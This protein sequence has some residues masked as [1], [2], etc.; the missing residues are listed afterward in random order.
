MNS[1]ECLEN[2]K[3]VA[4]HV[5]AD[6]EFFETCKCW[7]RSVLTLSPVTQILVRLEQNMWNRQY[8]SNQAGAGYCNG[9]RPRLLHPIATTAPMTSKILY[10]LLIVMHS[11]SRPFRETNCEISELSTLSNQQLLSDF[12]WTGY[13]IRTPSLRLEEPRTTSLFTFCPVNQNELRF[14][15]AAFLPMLFLCETVAFF[16][17][18]PRI[19]E[20]VTLAKNAAPQCVSIIDLLCFLTKNKH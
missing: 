1:R 9:C 16:Q 17:R 8:A 19:R 4:L 12:G 5:A 6:C 15:N 13:E 14:A 10:I 18:I 20:D 7:K 3:H 2:S 11:R